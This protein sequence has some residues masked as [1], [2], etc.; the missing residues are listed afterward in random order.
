MVSAGAEPLPPRPPAAGRQSLQQRGARWGLSLGGSLGLSEPH[1]PQAQS[2]GRDGE[3]ESQ[4][5]Q[6]LPK[7][8]C[9]VWGWGTRNDKTPGFLTFSLMT[10][11]PCSQVFTEHRLCA[12]HRG[13]GAQGK[14][15]KSQRA[16]T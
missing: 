13:W 6:A 7:V 4:A 3:T 1:N 14:R 11:E 10:I 12:R 9:K 15:T 5:G 8:T 2:W 16:D